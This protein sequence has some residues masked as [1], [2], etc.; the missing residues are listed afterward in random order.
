MIRE[1]DLFCIGRIARLHGLGGEVEISN[2]FVFTDLGRNNRLFF[3][4]T[5]G[6]KYTF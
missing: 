5:L 4:P 6:M 1:E 2:N 3:I